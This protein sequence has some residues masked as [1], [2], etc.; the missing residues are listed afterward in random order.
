MIPKKGFRKIVVD[1]KLYYWKQV[2][3]TATALADENR[4]FLGY[5]DREIQDLPG[6]AALTESFEGHTPIDT[7]IRVA[8]AIRRRMYG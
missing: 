5:F 2:H 3:G 1:G 8:E 6:D 4:N 7:P